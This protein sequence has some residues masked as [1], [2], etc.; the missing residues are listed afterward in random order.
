MS[1][2]HVGTSHQ[3]HGPVFTQSVDIFTNL[4]VLYGGEALLQTFEDVGLLEAGFTSKGK[5]NKALN[6]VFSTPF[7]SF[8]SKPVFTLASLLLLI[9]FK[10]PF[11]A[12]VALYVLYWIQFWRA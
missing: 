2:A 9:H 3:S 11:I 6:S 12:I 1:S 8:I 4:I 10:K 7:V 5:G